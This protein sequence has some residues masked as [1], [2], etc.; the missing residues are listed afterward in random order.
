MSIDMTLVSDIVPDENA[1]SHHKVRDSM[2]SF[3]HGHKSSRRGVRP[4]YTPTDPNGDVQIIIADF[5]SHPA[6]AA[7][8]RLLPSPKP[9]WYPV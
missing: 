7:S 3:R 1:R 8:R 9:G 4:A 5:S 2:S 6:R